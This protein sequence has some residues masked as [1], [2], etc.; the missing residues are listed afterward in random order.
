MTNE[1]FIRFYKK[2]YNCLKATLRLFVEFFNEITRTKRRDETRRATSDIITF[3]G[4]AYQC[5]FIQKR[6]L[7]RS[8]GEIKTS[9][10]I[11]ENVAF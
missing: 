11:N 10:Q 5:N 1:K 4:K 3:G 8:F 9:E 7:P 2:N 6:Y